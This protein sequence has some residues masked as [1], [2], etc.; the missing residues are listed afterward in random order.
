VRVLVVG[1]DPLN[2]LATAEWQHA[3]TNPGRPVL[4]VRATRTPPQPKPDCRVQKG[5]Y[6]DEA[7]LHPA[8][9]RWKDAPAS[10]FWN[11]P[12]VKVIPSLD[13][14]LLELQ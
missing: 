6:W 10:L 13:D 9:T 5:F 7:I 14:R 4:K 11:G 2:G 12:V 3:R 8:G 1:T